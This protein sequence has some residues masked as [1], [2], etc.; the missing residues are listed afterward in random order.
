MGINSNVYELQKY[1]TAVFLHI[2]DRSLLSNFGLFNSLP[3][4]AI[5]EDI[6]KILMVTHEPLYVSAAT[7]FENQSAELILNK[8]LPLF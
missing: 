6:R 5:Y 3:E 4:S 8:L 7:I 2:F 1:S